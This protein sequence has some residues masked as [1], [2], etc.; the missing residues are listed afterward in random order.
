[1]YGQGAF[2]LGS[3]WQTG[4]DV[5][6]GY[7]LRTTARFSP[8]FGIGISR[9]G[10]FIRT[11]PFAKTQ[12]NYPGVQTVGGGWGY[13]LRLKTVQGSAGVSYRLCRYVSMEAAI[14]AHVGKLHYA[15]GEPY[16]SIV[17]TNLLAS[18][19]DTFDH[20]EKMSFF[21]FLSSFDFLI[22]SQKNNNR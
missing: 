16:F 4:W 13:M 21:S 9:M 10:Y 15:D 19:A 14:S 2:G 7:R 1:M 22:F 5:Q 17:D 8:L 11:V 20:T 12:L 3:F 6:Y 18:R